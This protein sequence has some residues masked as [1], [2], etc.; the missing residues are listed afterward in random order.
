MIQKFLNDVDR[1]DR[2]RGVTCDPQP[3]QGGHFG[4]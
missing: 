1:V 4:G 3:A 2:G